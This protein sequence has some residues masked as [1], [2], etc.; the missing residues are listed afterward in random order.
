MEKRF[1]GIGLN[2]LSMLY[3][4]GY[5]VLEIVHTGIRM[6]PAIGISGGIQFSKPCFIFNCIEQGGAW[7]YQQT[8][9]EMHGIDMLDQVPPFKKV[10]QCYVAVERF[11]W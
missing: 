6:L 5:L 10:Q 11:P 1:D 9:R 3:Q 4:C 2:A 7:R 8:Y